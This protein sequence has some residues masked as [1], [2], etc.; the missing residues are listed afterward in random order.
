MVRGV[1]VVKNM[2]LL[3]RCVITDEVVFLCVTNLVPNSQSINLD[4]RR[5]L[6]ILYAH[7]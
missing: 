1:I 4:R 3:M 6:H 7:S 2:A 5:Q